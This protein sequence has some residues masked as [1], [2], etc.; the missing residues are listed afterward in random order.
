MLVLTILTGTVMS[1]QPLKIDTLSIERAV[2]L[3]LENHPSLRNAEANVRGASAGHRLAL[4]NYF[5][6]I[7]F[8]ASA[9]YTQG[10]FVSNPLFP[11]RY[12]I[13]SSY[14]GGLQAQQ[15]LYDFGK[16][17]NRVGANT[18]FTRAAEFDYTTA[19]EL[20]ETNVLVAY[21]AYLAAI[22]VVTV[23]EEAVAQAAK[24]LSQANA[25]YSVGRRPQL[26]VTKAEVDLA[27]A[28][29][30]LIA[31]TSQM[32]VAKVQLENAMGVH[33]VG[34]YAVREEV[35]TDP[36]TAG[37][38]SARALAM[39]NRSELLAARARVDANRSLT[40]AIWGQ[41]LPTISAVGT[42]NWNGFEPTPLY[43][44]WNAGVQFS[45]PIF[46][47]FSVAAQ[48]DQAEAT[49]DAAQATLDTEAESVLLEVDQT[50]LTLRQTEERKI[51]AGKLVELAE[52]NLNL[53]ERQ[54]AA[55]VGTSLDVSDAQL[56]RSN[57]R[58][59]N[60]QALYDYSNSLVRLRRATGTLH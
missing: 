22:D 17:P 12:Q 60:I 7:T 36:F 29:V 59:T 33:P 31:A 20:V 52:A 57:A 58:I 2:E 13:F 48:V 10:V 9:T 23:N 54:Y 39:K 6:S 1:A 53:A 34:T 24:H 30:N 15:L 3:A 35:H 47:G 26:D 8:S 42:W 16:T 4:A 19:R 40:S 37:L 28:N 56:A 14:T 21:F 50:Y 55:G 44:R 27:N 5:P 38:D 45:L 41:H 11:S 49:A 25:F 18:D 43:G 32:Q 46:Q 51:A